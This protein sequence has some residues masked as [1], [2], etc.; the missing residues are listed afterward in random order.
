MKRH[1]WK[2]ALLG[3]VLAVTLVASEAKAQWCCDWGCYCPVCVTY[4][5]VTWS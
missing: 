4:Y 5:P 2:I 1:G 3:A